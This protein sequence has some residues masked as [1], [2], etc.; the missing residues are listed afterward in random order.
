MGVGAHTRADWAEGLGVKTMAE[1]A[2]VDVL[3]WVGCWSF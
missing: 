2:N 1:D 3:Y